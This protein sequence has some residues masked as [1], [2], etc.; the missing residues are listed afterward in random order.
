MGSDRLPNGYVEM[1]SLDAL[2]SLLLSR[3]NRAANLCAQAKQAVLLW[4]EAEAEVKVV[5][6]MLE[7][8]RSQGL[9]AGAVLQS[10][11]LLPPLQPR[12]PELVAGSALVA[13]NAATISAQ[14][15]SGS[16]D[17][18][19]LTTLR[20]PAVSVLALDKRGR[21]SR[22]Q[23]AALPVRIVAQRSAG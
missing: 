7:K 18:A 3:M 12:Q 13:P 4:A 10:R 15:L 19:N 22:L 6:W 17:V 21:Q 9:H 1:C 16:C 14:P 20:G 5:R 23:R 2:E 11:S 8:R